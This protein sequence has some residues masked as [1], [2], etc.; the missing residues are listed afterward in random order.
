MSKLAV[1]H[2]EYSFQ[3]QNCRSEIAVSK[4]GRTG[5]QTQGDMWPRCLSSQRDLKKLEVPFFTKGN[6]CLIK[7]NINEGIQ[8]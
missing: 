3:M 5:I 2:S 1:S 7:R 4:H 6:K 8:S